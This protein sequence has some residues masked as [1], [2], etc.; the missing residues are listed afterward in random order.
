[1]G[2]GTGSFGKRRNK[3]HTLCVR[4]GRRSFHLQKSRCSACAFPAARVRKYNWSEKAIRRKT[5]GT[6]RMKYLRHLPRR[7]KTNF[8]EGT[9]ATPRNK[10]A[11]AA[12]S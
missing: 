1:M 11:A 5:T 9:Q 2:K 3:T 6:G 7:F 10:G 8:R 12:S 4:C